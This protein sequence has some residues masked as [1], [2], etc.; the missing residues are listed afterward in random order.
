MRAPRVTLLQVFAG[1][2]A[3]LALLL[4]ALLA[5]FSAATRR[6]VLHPAALHRQGPAP[7]PTEHLTFRTAASRDWD[8][9]PIWTDLSY[10]QSD[11]A[12]PPARRRVVVSVQKSMV[13]ARG[14]FAGVVR[15]GL[16]THAIDAISSLRVDDRAASDPHRIFLADPAGHLVT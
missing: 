8:G 9:V 12:L 3:A 7:D 4:G 1:S 11:S 2:A 16:L 6:S 10:A 13:D 14:R 15:A 5:L